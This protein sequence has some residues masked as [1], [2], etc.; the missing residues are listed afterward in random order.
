MIQ[1]AKTFTGAFAAGRDQ[2]GLLTFSDGTWKDSSPSTDFQ[3]ILGYS[4]ASGSGSGA[5]DNIQCNGGTGTAQAISLAYN[6]LYKMALPGALNVIVLE[7]DGLP[8]TLVYNWWDG[9]NAGIDSSSGCQDATGKTVAGGGWKTSASMRT[10]D[11]TGY[12]MNSGGTGFMA[13]IPTGTIG[14]FYTSDPSQ[15]SYQVVMF[16]P[17]QSGDSNNNNSVNTS[18]ANGCNF[19]GGTTTDY[20]DFAWLPNKDVYGNLVNPTNAYK[21]VSVTSNHILLSG[22]ACG[23]SGCTSPD[24]NNTH[25]AALNATDNAAYNA[26]TNATLPVTMFVVGLGGNSGDP[27]DAVLLQRIANDPNGD[28]Y[29]NPVTYQPCA[30]ET[31]CITYSSQPQ[32]TFI[33]A[34]N[35]ASLGAAFQAI[36]SQILRIS[37]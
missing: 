32:G 24:W 35:S 17:W 33:Y 37:H 11:S 8:N 18:N 1:K 14:S 9:S 31:G 5:L 22:P 19:S 13:N 4:N 30:Q 25:A 23:R 10:W 2:I 26:R 6:E 21:T 34:Q 12:N 15:G 20:S 7:T 27:P 3:T 29:N 36:A 16:N 28:L